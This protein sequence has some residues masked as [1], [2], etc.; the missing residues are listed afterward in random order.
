MSRPPRG[1]RF[2]L[3]L[4]HV[5]GTA[6]PR[7]PAERAEPRDLLRP[8]RPLAHAARD[9]ARQAPPAGLGLDSAAVRARMVER[10]RAEGIGCEPVLQAFGRVE[11]HRFVDSALATQAYEDTSLPI[12]HGQ[13][14]SKPSVV[15]RMLAL[16]F[17]SERAR[18]AGALGRVLEI[19]TGCG[20]QAALLSLLA[21][22][23]LSIERVQPLHDKARLHLHGWRQGDVR[24]VYGDGRLGHAPWA[25][26]DHIVAA[27]GGDA[28]PPAWLEQL[29]IGGRLVAPMQ[30]ARA[31]GQVLL[32]IDRTADGWREQRVG[33]VHF[34]P[35]KSGRE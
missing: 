26:Y 20:Y 19:G 16:L 29:A 14:I 30:D 1:A 7:R 25:P 21:R 2:P 8:Q 9:A 4:D 6:A 31:G 18:A 17:E 33:A 3:G 28:L 15:A 24:L 23:V 32:V 11:R 5:H 10:L 27:A 13:T 34:V 12:G 22:G 35:L